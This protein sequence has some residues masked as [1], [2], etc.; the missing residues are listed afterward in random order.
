MWNIWKF[1]VS[2]CGFFINLN[3]SKGKGKRVKLIEMIL[4]VSRKEANKA[5]SGEGKYLG[6]EGLSPTTTNN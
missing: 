2:S 4:L 6:A 1:S 5:A 3:Y